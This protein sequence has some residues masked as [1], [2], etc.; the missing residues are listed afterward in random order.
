M[1]KTLHFSPAL[2]KLLTLRIMCSGD[3]QYASSL[4]QPENSILVSLKQIKRSYETV[5]V[6]PAL[7]DK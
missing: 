7:K 6:L 4:V 1:S 2:G 5:L 3:E